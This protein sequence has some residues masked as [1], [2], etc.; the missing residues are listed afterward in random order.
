MLL[1][2]KSDRRSKKEAQKMKITAGMYCESLIV[3]FVRQIP[4]VK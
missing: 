2:R 1:Q 3:S 4:L